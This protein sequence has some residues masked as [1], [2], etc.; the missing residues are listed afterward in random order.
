MRHNTS[1]C[2]FVRQHRLALL[3]LAVG[4]FLG[5]AWE[6]DARGYTAISSC[7]WSKDRSTL[8]E[9]IL[10]AQDFQTNF[11]RCRREC[12]NGYRVCVSGC[13]NLPS[14]A[15]KMRCNEGCI[16]GYDACVER[17]KPDPSSPGSRPC[18]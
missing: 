17:C 6:V 5:L 15:D 10:L 12:S 3:V 13:N 11:E 14:D 16:R 8:E 18:C 7:D 2:C 9:M 4:F 1:R